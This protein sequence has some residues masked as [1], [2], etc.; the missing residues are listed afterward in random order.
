ML[1]FSLAYVGTGT[2]LLLL[3]AWHEHTQGGELATDKV[4]STVEGAKEEAT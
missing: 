3:Y 4:A 1:Y 2:L